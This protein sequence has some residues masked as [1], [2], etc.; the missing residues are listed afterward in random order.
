MEECDN[1]PCSTGEFCE[2]R[3]GY[4]YCSCDAGFFFN[5]SSCEG[6]IYNVEFSINFTLFMF[7]FIIRNQ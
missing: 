4:Y 6:M 7:M 3:E 2:E 1:S 5:G